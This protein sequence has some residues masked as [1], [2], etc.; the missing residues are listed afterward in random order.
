[1][2]ST[3]EIIAR[4]LNLTENEF[5]GVDQSV[6][7]PRESRLLDTEF[8]G[9]AV[10]APRQIMTG[11]H[12]KLPL[13]MATRLSGER[14][15]DV[16]L[17]DN[18]ILVG[19]N[20]RDGTV[21]FANALVSEKE[22]RSRG[23]RQKVA[24]GPKP[25]GLALAA[26]Q[27][28]EL[29][30]RGRLHI[31]WNTGTWA[32]GVI[33]YDWPSNTVVVELKGDEAAQRSPARSVHPPP[34]P[35]CAGPGG[36][37]KKEIG[38]LPCYLPISKTPRFPDSGVSFTA[39]FRVE[40]GRQSLNIFGAFTLPVMDFHLPEKKVVD[41]FQDG[42]REN[43]AAVVPMTMAVLALDWEVP[44]KFDW[45]VPVYGEQL[46]VGMSARGCFAINALATGNK[47]AL[48]P[49]K[50]ICYIVADGRIFGPRSFEIPR[51]K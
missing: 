39:E 34:N 43:V 32:L 5:F 27:L 33:Y 41:Q 2:A 17:R 29:D 22:L 13:I 20:L 50:Y 51:V 36:L 24:K 9:V 15:W 12:D 18:C 42:R 37:P 30:A 47:Q 25:P 19:T 40:Q 44:L 6:L 7:S 23:G 31:K 26:A 16:R 10:N 4:I 49:G 45:A 38:V 21:R 35:A 48:S 1:M 14:D 46:R 28:T 3:A 11:R 8:F